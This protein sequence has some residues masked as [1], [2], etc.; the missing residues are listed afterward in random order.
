MKKL[1]AVIL[2]AVFLLTASCA[3]R[4]RIPDGY[5][6][7]T[8][9]DITVAVPEYWELSTWDNGAEDRA[10]FRYGEGADIKLPL[11]IS[12]SDAA[13][14]LADIAILEM[15]TGWGDAGESRAEKLERTGQMELRIYTILEH[16]T[17]EI[18]GMDAARFRVQTKAGH[19]AIHYY[20]LTDDYYYHFE[21]NDNGLE[22]TDNFSD[23]IRQ[24]MDSIRVTA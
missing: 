2:A 18:A 9:C 7:T 20:M 8:F 14:T 22:I 19:E 1:L 17:C 3:P 15:L 16:E 11:D 10:S 13:S 4:G 21:F 23:T 6:E 12:A 24:V 5:A